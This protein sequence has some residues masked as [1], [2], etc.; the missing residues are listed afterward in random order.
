MSTPA[1]SANPL[2]KATSSGFQRAERNAA[3]QLVLIYP[4]YGQAFVLKPPKH[5]THN[6]DQHQKACV[7]IFAPPPPAAS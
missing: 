7:S 5:S 4:K 2:M 6:F 3:G 1:S